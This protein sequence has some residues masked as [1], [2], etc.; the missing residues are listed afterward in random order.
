MET[1]LHQST[2]RIPNH[3][4]RAGP[5]QFCSA[6]LAGGN[7]LAPKIKTTRKGRLAEIVP[8]LILVLFGLLR[9]GHFDSVLVRIL[10]QI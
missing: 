10:G 4:S 7:A 5:V 3:R 9:I 1:D 8:A 2:N 6:F